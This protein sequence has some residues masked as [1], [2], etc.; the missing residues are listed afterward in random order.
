MCKKNIELRFKLPKPFP[1]YNIRTSVNTY[2]YKSISRPAI[3][4][5]L[6]SMATT[7]YE[8]N[9]IETPVMSKPSDVN[10]IN[11]SSSN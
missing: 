8:I 1:P 5:S 11:L 2:R 3:K 4:S 10:P 6:R 7:L 9:Y